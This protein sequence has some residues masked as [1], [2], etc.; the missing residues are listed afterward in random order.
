MCLQIS[1][2]GTVYMLTG[3]KTGTAYKV[4]VAARSPD[5]EGTS[6]AYIPVRIPGDK[7][8]VLLEIVTVYLLYFLILLW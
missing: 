6:T 8:D 2:D 4:Y 5:G 1:V 3:L 7:G